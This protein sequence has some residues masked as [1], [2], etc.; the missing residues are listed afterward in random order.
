[1]GENK[2]ETMKKFKRNF[3]ERGDV[4]QLESACLA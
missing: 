2:Q 4:A 1:M 3:K